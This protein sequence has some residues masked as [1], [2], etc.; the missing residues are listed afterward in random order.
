MKNIP[1]PALPLE[2][3]TAVLGA[4]RRTGIAPRVVCLSKL[5]S[6]GQAQPELALVS[7]PGWFRAYESGAG[8]VRELERDL[9]SLGGR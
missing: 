9:G 1:F 7:A 2:E 8:W 6:A 5:Q 3:R 4:L